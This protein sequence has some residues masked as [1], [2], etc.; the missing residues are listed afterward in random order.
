MSTTYQI[1]PAADVF[2]MMSDA[3]LD[4][5]AA[6]I[7]A[8]GLN[9]P[10]A[11]HGNLILDGR[12]R[13][14]ACRRADVTPIYR[15]VRTTNPVAYVIS[16]NIHRRHL[17]KNQRA[18][19][20][21]ELANLEH[22]TNQYGKKVEVQNCTSTLA[23][24]VTI[25]EAAELMGVSRRSVASA[26]KR[27]RD[28]PEEHEAVKRGEKIKRTTSRDKGDYWLTT[29]VHAYADASGAKRSE[30]WIRDN[31]GKV[32][33]ETLPWFDGKDRRS[34]LTDSQR[35]EVI[36]VVRAFV[37]TENKTSDEMLAAQADALRAQL[38]KTAQ[39][40]LDTAIRVHRRLLEREF[41][42][43]VRTES[44]KMLDDEI[45][46]RHA[47]EYQRY[48]E[49]VDSYKGIFTYS[50]YKML[51][52]FLHPDRH[53]TEQTKAAQ[54]FRLVTEKE[55]ILCGLKESV[56]AERPSTLPSSAAELASRR[57][58]N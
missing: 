44:L 24:T 18:A 41:D 57:R 53:P 1:H 32:L 2:P 47:R 43:R 22:G 12:N 8:N 5:L 11:I 14:E 33:T 50:E 29:A 52:G 31:I 19:I 13:L 3:D 17:E 10:I 46:P 54:L 9:D 38:A 21:A 58:V 27:L 37:E 28:H 30:T 56:K 4:A 26:K 25:E 6:D 49:I 42:E 45:L 48:K 20:A 7:K 39:E 16:A 34:L 35:A 55:E 15:E 40:K 23:P 51:K 36:S